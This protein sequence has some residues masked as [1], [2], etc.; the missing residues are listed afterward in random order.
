MVSALGGFV[1]V[2]WNQEAPILPK[3]IKEIK[4]ASDSTK[5]E[6]LH[7][8]TPSFKSRATPPLSLSRESQD[9]LDQKMTEAIALVDESEPEKAA[10]ILKEILGINPDHE[11][12]LV[13][14]GMLHLIDF[15]KPE[16]AAGYL[17]RSLDLNPQNKIVLSEL[18]QIYKETSN[19]EQ[20]AQFMEN[21]YS[22]HPDQ[23]DI[24]AK[25]AEIYLEDG[26]PE[27][28][29]RILENQASQTSNTEVISLYAEALRDSGQ[30]DKALESHKKILEIETDRVQNG[31]YQDD[32]DQAQEKISMA[33]MEIIGDYMEQQNDTKAQEELTKLREELGEKDFSA[34]LE[35]YTIQKKR[36]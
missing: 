25:L 6:E 20:G 12:A 10:Q 26:K 17:E 16:E 33:R 7:Q 24:G 18:T 15:K 30:K 3:E 9:E 32:P 19:L 8:E 2:L 27:E 14:L 1:W 5:K 29:V 28:S 21:L 4:T 31:F 35:A 11:G 22:K 34:L 13:E 36:L 23:P